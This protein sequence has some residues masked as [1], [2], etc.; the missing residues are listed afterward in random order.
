[1]VPPIWNWLREHLP[2]RVKTW[3]WFATDPSWRREYLTVHRPIR[4]RQRARRSAIRAISSQTGN[5]IASGPFA[6]MKY[7]ASWGDTHFTNRL[8]GTYEK[9]VAGIVEG[10]CQRGYQ[11]V[12]DVGAADGYYACGLMWRMPAARMKAF[13]MQVRLHPLLREIAAKNGLEERLEL[14]GVCTVETLRRELDTSGRCLVVCDVDG[15][16]IDLLDPALVP[17]LIKADLLVEVHDR[18]RPNVSKALTERFQ[19]THSVEFVVQV[20]RGLHDLPTSIRLDANLAVK[21]MNEGRGPDNDWLW[22]RSKA[23]L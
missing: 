8:L 23:A 7:V 4:E 20:P 16:E 6:G 14:F 2:A 5:V 15:V 3:W 11:L 10:I 19:P 9:E 21:V 22:M 18:I 17:Q 1:M 12:V 13:E